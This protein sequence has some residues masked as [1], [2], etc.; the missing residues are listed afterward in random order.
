MLFLLCS[1]HRALRAYR[2]LETVSRPLHPYLSTSSTFFDIS[3]YLT[4]IPCLWP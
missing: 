2:C 1:Y 3:S 4:L